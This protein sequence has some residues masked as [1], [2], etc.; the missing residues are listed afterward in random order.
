MS[1]PKAEL[2]LL[3][4]QARRILMSNT[5]IDLEYAKQ[6]YSEL[7]RAKQKWLGTLEK[8]AATHPAVTPPHSMHHA[9]HAHTDADLKRNCDRVAGVLSVASMN[10]PDLFK[11]KRKEFKNSENSASTRH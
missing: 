8:P 5:D 10:I 2:E 3:V 11:Q 7:N 4:N 1:S 9:H 6:L